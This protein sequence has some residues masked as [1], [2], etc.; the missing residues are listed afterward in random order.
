MGCIFLS[1]G[2]C[3]FPIIK[4]ALIS[5]HLQMD[6]CLNSEFPLPEGLEITEEVLINCWNSFFFPFVKSS[7]ISFPPVSDD[8]LLYDIEGGVL[9]SSIGSIVLKKVEKWKLIKTNGQLLL[10]KFANDNFTSPIL[11]LLGNIFIRHGRDA[12]KVMSTFTDEDFVIVKD[13][14]KKFN[15]F[16]FISALAFSMER[17]KD[18][19][20]SNED[21]VNLWVFQFGPDWQ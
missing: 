10:E 4:T 6:S 9:G 2:N 17:N 19:T 8:S 7:L 3:S 20:I 5:A 14:S 11:G 15:E 18:A 16:T 12:Y 1:E 21:F 13:Y